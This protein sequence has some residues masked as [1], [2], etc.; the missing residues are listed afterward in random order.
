[1]V[2]GISNYQ[3]N[4]I[5]DLKY[6]DKDARAFADWL[7]SPAGGSI[8]EDNINLLTNEKATI[9]AVGTALHSM[10]EVCKS[11]ERFIFYFSGH[12]DVETKTRNQPGYLL[13][14]DSPANVYMVGALNL[15]DLQEI[16]STISEN[17]VKVVLITDACHAGKLAG[18]GVGGAQATAA[19][20]LQQ[21]ANEVKIMSC[22]PNEFSLEGEQWGGGRG[23]FSYNLLEGLTGLADNNTDNTVNLFEI[24]RF[25]EDRVP[26]QTAPHPQMPLTVGDLNFHLA[27]VDAASIAALK[28]RK[29][30]PGQLSSFGSKGIE[31]EVL[32]RADSLTRTRYRAFQRALH[33]G[34]LLAD[35]DS[36]ANV[37]FGQ[38]VMVEVLR[39]LYGILRR[40]FAVALLDEVQQAINALLADDPYEANNWRYNPDKYDKYPAYLQRALE[41]LGDGHY[42]QRSVLSKLRYFEGYLFYRKIVDIS[43]ASS[44]DSLRNIAKS[45][46]LEA[47]ELEP[48]AAHIYHAIGALYATNNP[49]RT[50]S[51]Q[52]WME[53][54][55]EY[56]PTWQLPYLDLSYEY[57]LSQSNVANAEKWLDKVLE[58]GSDSYVVLE[59]LSW[60]YQWQNRTQESLT[61]CDTMIARKPE[62]FNAWSTKGV[63]H[64]MRNELYEADA[65][66]RRS[67]ELEPGW[68]NWA[69]YFRGMMLG[70][71]RRWPEAKVFLDKNIL[72]A[73]ADNIQKTGMIV[74]TVQGII[75]NQNLI[76]QARPY[77]DKVIEL[78]LY[79]SSVSF[80]L[81]GIGIMNFNKGN[82]SEAE[83]YFLKSLQTDTTHSNSM[84]SNQLY[85][86]L[87]AEK[88][89]ERLRADSLYQAAFRAAPRI[90]ALDKSFVYCTIRL[91]YGRFLIQQKRHA[92]ARQQ[93]RL[94]EE[95][96]PKCYE[97]QYGYALL[98]AADKR[99]NEALD[100]LEKALDYWLPEAGPMLEEPLFQK[101]RKT[102]RF[103]ALLAKHFP[104][105]ASNKN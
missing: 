104:E 15:R 13:C 101:L 97:A 22:Q 49:S 87:V 30:P 102:K 51:M 48:E 14:H 25:L 67:I 38:L 19:A 80:A 55:V 78:Q 27:T 4:S 85:L 61:L 70:Q 42:M 23:V 5:P 6:A 21:V 92:E 76:L 81:T 43:A 105:T 29:T 99:H 65:C 18:E 100:H 90:S 83:T 59:R 26:A 72:D 68:S 71:M 16:I 37:L 32:A 40:N 50:D 98:A 74:H 1:M 89:G 31:D 79:P 69:L 10:L 52:R 96:Q 75:N 35:T 20:L 46:Y 54:A 12:G 17:G 3:H 77:F 93:F 7:Q 56:A 73:Q 103:Q 82:L 88:R 9:S 44:R 41:L 60:L 57:F 34:D 63:T 33:D 66:F 47:A 84:L 86:A 58:T 2:V 64:L 45:K 95:F 24:R 11:G 28:Q 94:A 62:L 39:P 91:H 8:P 36:S 53:K